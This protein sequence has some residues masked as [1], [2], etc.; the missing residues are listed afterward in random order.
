VFSAQGIAADASSAIPDPPVQ[1]DR[2]GGDRLALLDA[3]TP[4][5]LYVVS[6]D[7]AVALS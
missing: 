4:S 7:D 1:A 3:G 5:A 6:R 2:S